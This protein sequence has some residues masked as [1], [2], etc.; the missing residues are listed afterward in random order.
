MPYNYV[1]DSYYYCGI[2]MLAQVFFILSQS[3]HLTDRQTDGQTD[4]ETVCSLLDCIACNACSK[5]K[6]KLIQIVALCV[7]CLTE[8]IQCVSRKTVPT[9]LLLCVS[10]SNTNRYQY[11]IGKHVP[12]KI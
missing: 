7:S 8:Y 12:E 5:V 2:R 10:L 11:K 3:T 1:A 6:A 4:G 9:F